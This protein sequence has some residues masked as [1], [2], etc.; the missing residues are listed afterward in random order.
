MSIYVALSNI[1]LEQN[2]LSYPSADVPYFSPSLAVGMDLLLVKPHVTRKCSSVIANPRAGKMCPMT[3][4][5][6]QNQI[7]W[8]N[9]GSIRA[10]EAQPYINMSHLSIS[11]NV[12]RSQ[13]ELKTYCMLVAAHKLKN[14]AADRLYDDVTMGQNKTFEWL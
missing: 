3:L 9:I 8:V 13:V 7:L 5:V 14:S 4:S 1:A 12:L 10:W 11:L 2:G 6:A